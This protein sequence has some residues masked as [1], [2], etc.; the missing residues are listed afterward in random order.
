M[1]NAAD[2]RMWIGGYLREWDGLCQALMWRL[3]ERF[4]SVP[5]DGIGSATE[6]YQIERDAGRIHTGPIPASGG[7]FVYLAVPGVPDGH[8]GFMLDGDTFFNASGYLAEEW[9][10]S[11]A[12]VSSLDGYVISK[13]ATILGWSYMN[14]GNTVEGW[15]GPSSPAGGGDSAE[16]ITGEEENMFVFIEGK[17]GVRSGGIYYID[18]GVATFLGTGGTPQAKLTFDQGTALKKRVSG[19]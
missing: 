3:C 2:V 18:G 5:Y 15:E 16:I 1:F 17:A 9:T 4:G 6:A 10:D 7:V 12:G 8:V 13:G 11:D 14:G 19:I